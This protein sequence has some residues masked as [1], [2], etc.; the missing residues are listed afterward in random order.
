MT[1]ELGP[2]ARA[3]LDAAR[4]GMS[5]DAA[6]VRRVRA[7][8]DQAAVA[9][10]AGTAVGLKL[11]V[12]GIVAAVVAGGVYLQRGPAAEATR[13]GEL[14]S[15]SLPAVRDPSSPAAVPVVRDP[16]SPAV[17]P[18]VREP[19]SPV[20]VPVTRAPASPAGSGD[21]RIA[22]EEPPAIAAPRRVDPAPTAPHRSSPGTHAPGSRRGVTAGSHASPRALAARPA[23]DLAREVE[24]VD[25]AMAALRR[26]DAG[27]A[28][29]TVQRHAAETAGNGQLAEDAAA[30]EIEALCQLHDPAR[31]A[32]LAAFDVR[33]PRSAQRSRLD[34][35]CR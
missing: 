26:G 35:S 32:K 11:L 14:A 13:P 22:I 16:S 33:F 5:P 24:L 12:V 23:I 3:L 21:A 17:V 1:E 15:P 4:A 7:K 6:A 27:T 2:E 10:G 19:A 9:G 34:R 29:V 28:L 18:V 30:I 31:N 20:V 25:L 8:L